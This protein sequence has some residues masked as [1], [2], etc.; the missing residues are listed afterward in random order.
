MTY[1]FPE[2]Q[3]DNGREST[4]LD[5][6]L[7]GAGNNW[8]PLQVQHDA[9]APGGGGV[10]FTSRWGQTNTGQSRPLGTNT[11]SD[12]E[13]FT[14]DST[15]AITKDS[16][17]EQ[18]LR[19]IHDYCRKACGYDFPSVR[20]RNDCDRLDVISNYENLYQYNDAGVT[21]KG[22]SANLK[23][24]PGPEGT[25]NVKVMRQLSFSAI[26]EARI[27]KLRHLDNSAQ[28]SAVALNAVTFG[29]DN[30]V[31]AVGD[32]NATPADEVGY[33]ADGGA[34]WTFT[35]INTLSTAGDVA[36]D[37]AIF[38]DLLLI[39]SPQ[40]GV[41]YAT[42]QS[43]RDSATTPWT[44]ATV[45]GA[46]W[47]TNF[48][49][50][51]VV[52]NAN[53]VIAFGDGGYIWTSSDG[54]DFTLLSAGTVTANNLT[55]GVRIDNDR[56]LLAGAS[57][58]LI[59][60]D[61]DV[62]STITVTNASGTVT[63]AIT[64]IA[65]PDRR[66]TEYFV[67]TDAGEIIRS[68]DSGSNWQVEYAGTSITDMEFVGYRGAYLYFL[69]TDTNTTVYRDLS[70]GAFGSDVETITPPTDVAINDIAVRDNNYAVAV[71]E[72]ESTNGY[73]GIIRD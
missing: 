46:A 67:G 26:D 58:T 63:D 43:I 4:I 22:F 13:R 71:G 64:A 31:F 9:T 27:V 40:S 48:P 51:V 36:N 28:G 69:D 23:I 41:E 21:S 68:L 57:G 6:Q 29:C 18:I 34:T 42:V 55:V 49:N 39:S 12:P 73:I 7:G 1:T 66:E 8:T 59:L 70:G 45:S 35:E 60:Y 52:V 62:L 56:A 5:I 38:G 61:R 14:F 17:I 53:L 16:T 50:A 54:K 37:V 47:S 65:V 20:F 15:V 25:G 72:I 24:G 2:S 44:T 10:S 11:D 19:D 3:W 30:E 33:S 32:E